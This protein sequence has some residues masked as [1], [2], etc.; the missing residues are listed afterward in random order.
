MT[1]D[2]LKSL[3]KGWENITSENNPSSY[4]GKIGSY[5]MPDEDYFFISIKSY[6]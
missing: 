1:T 4:P 5:I 2:T 3:P 6:S